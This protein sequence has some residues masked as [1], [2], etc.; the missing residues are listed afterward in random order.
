MD[1]RPVL[2]ATA[3]ALV[4]LISLP[5]VAGFFGRLHPA[6]DSFAHF[7]LHLA[8]LMIA[9]AVPLLFG[10][11][12]REALMAIAFGLAATTT[13][14]GA[15]FLP[16]LRPVHAAFAPRGEDEPVYRL[17]Q[18]NLRFDNREP[19]KVLSL[20]ARERPDVVTLNE[21]S[22][23]W[24]KKIA[25]LEAAY[26]YRLVCTMDNDA[27]GVTIL[28]LRPFAEGK[29]GRCIDGGTFGTATFDFGGRPLDIA[30]MHL[31]W[32]WPFDQAEQVAGI[33][34][35]LAGLP[36]TVLLAGDLNATP[37][38]AAAERI[39]QAGGFRQVGP[40]GPTWLF[41]PMPDFLRFAGLPI[42]QVFA[43]GG[44]RVHSAKRLEPVGSDHL[45]VLVEFSLDPLIRAPVEPAQSITASLQG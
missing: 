31:H 7:R 32:P 34:A 10:S 33:A 23:M 3:L 5:L 27:G 29:E 20:I 43:K 25:P 19:E 38:S 37:W 45:P 35:D 44:V 26:P 12:R 8:I 40:I 15:S 13:V 21:V 6:L 24:A 36:E 14:T 11:F 18:I 41:Q 4:V 30:A 28:S 9:C 22:A 42:D 17:L 1:R 16:G 39:A 2:G